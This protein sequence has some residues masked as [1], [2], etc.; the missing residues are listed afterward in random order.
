MYILGKS[1]KR[2][3]ERR[4]VHRP[5]F[6]VSKIVFSDKSFEAL[7]EVNGV[8]VHGLEGLH[9]LMLHWL[10]ERIQRREREERERERE[11]ERGIGERGMV[12]GLRVKR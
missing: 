9:T 4:E 12:G 10:E 11:R 6:F 3:T 7:V 2:K 5:A 1:Y 8:K